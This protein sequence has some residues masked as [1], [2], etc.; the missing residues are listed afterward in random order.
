[1]EL[2]TMRCTF[3]CVLYRVWVAGYAYV[4]KLSIEEKYFSQKRKRACSFHVNTVSQAGA[5]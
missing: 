1:M 4:H 3:S 5:H 2:I